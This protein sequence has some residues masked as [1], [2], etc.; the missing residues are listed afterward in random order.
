M[1][2]DTFLG[3]GMELDGTSLGA[4]VHTTHKALEDKLRD[5]I[6]C[7]DGRAA[8]VAAERFKCYAVGGIDVGLELIEK[9]EKKAQE[10]ILR[11]QQTEGLPKFFCV[12]GDGLKWGKQD[13]IFMTAEECAEIRPGSVLTSTDVDSSSHHRD[14]FLPKPTHIYLYIL[15]HKL[16]YL[17]PL[18]K[19]IRSEVLLSFQLSNS[20]LVILQ[21]SPKRGQTISTFLRLRHSWSQK[22]EFFSESISNPA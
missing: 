3:D 12:A 19:R 11:M 6:G 21:W 1:T 7:G 9:F 5:D 8:I 15:E 17:V 14:V 4:F 10:S 20:K 16:K 22:D 2:D 18:L 13:H